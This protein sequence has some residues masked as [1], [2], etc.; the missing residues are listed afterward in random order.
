M[1]K[2]FISRKRKGQV[3][4]KSSQFASRPFAPSRHTPVVQGKSLGENSTG[5]KMARSAKETNI[6]SRV[7][8]EPPA[9]FTPGLPPSQ[10]AES[11]AD[12]ARESEAIESEKIQRSTTSKNWLEKVSVTPPA[13][14]STPHLP[15]QPKLTVGA[16]GDKYEQEADRV[17]QQVVNRIH[18]PHLSP[19]NSESDP[20][21][22]KI[23]IRAKGAEGGEVSGEWE[24]QLNRARNGGQPLSPTVKEPMERGFG[25]DFSGVRVHTG[26]QADNLANS[27]QA[28]A[29]TTGEDVFFRQGA[30]APG[31]R[32]GQELIAHE[33]THVVQ[34]SGGQVPIAH[35]EMQPETASK[36]P[37]ASASK[38][39]IQ[40]D[41]EPDDIASGSASQN[42]ALRKFRKNQ[43][44]EIGFRKLSRVKPGTFNVERENNEIKKLQAAQIEKGISI[45][46][47]LEG[48]AISRNADFVMDVLRKGT[49][50]VVTIV[51]IPPNFGVDMEAEYLNYYRNHPDPNRPGKT[52]PI[53]YEKNQTNKLSMEVTLQRLPSGCLYGWIERYLD[54]DTNEIT[55]QY[56]ENSQRTC[57]DIAEI[58]EQDRYQELMSKVK[59]IEGVTFKNFPA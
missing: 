44:W 25:A 16:A 2:D 37:S 56:V 10:T 55:L 26:A 28:K 18:A 59:Q 31:S 30:Y 51:A 54:K 29:F 36:N 52:F 14:P 49:D 58:D 22:R 42:K 39:T 35:R 20:V 45:N 5:D 19:P 53:E 32:G 50:K 34:Q 11:I 4:R 33:L 43:Y 15:I 6:L 47:S 46:H 24:S 7:A 21:Q 13:P 48:I 8:I 23:A 9:S 1:T 17:A 27:I 12:V 3:Q 41:Y 38:G 57:P 40:R